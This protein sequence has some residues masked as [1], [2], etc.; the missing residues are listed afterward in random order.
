MTVATV[1][2]NSVSLRLGI[3]IKVRGLAGLG[4]RLRIARLFFT[5]GGAVAGVPV[6]VEA[7]PV[8]DQTNGD[9]GSE[10]AMTTADVEGDRDLPRG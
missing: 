8:I 3:K 2:L 10:G 5:V 1:N 6:E 9:R 4:M 7:E